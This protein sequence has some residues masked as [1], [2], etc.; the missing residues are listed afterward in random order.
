MN[1]DSSNRH[2]SVAGK[3]TPGPQ[4]N[5]GQGN[6]IRAR[7]MLYEGH[8]FLQKL[9]VR[10][11]SPLCLLIFLSIFLAEPVWQNAAVGI[12]FA[13]ASV[14][15]LYATR[16]T[17]QGRLHASVR[18]LMFGVILFEMVSMV[19]MPRG[20]ALGLLA[21]AIVIIYASF[22]TLRLLYL[23]IGATFASYVAVELLLYLDVVPQKPMSPLGLAIYGVGFSIIVLGVIFTALRHGKKMHDAL[24]EQIQ[25]AYQEQRSMLSTASRLEKVLE[26]TVYSIRDVSVRFSEQALDQSSSIAQMSG[27]LGQV[28]EIAATT[29]ASAHRT[30]ALAAK[31]QERASHSMEKLKQV[32]QGFG[33]VVEINELVKA[34]FDD[35]AAQ[36]ERIEDILRTN[37][38]L[39]AQIKI[40]AVNA[41]IQAAKAGEYGMGFRVV[42]GEL[43]AMIQRTDDSLG[44]SR[45]LLDGIRTRALKSAETISRSSALLGS[46]S[47]EL[48][49]T[50][51]MI[52]EITAGVVDTS[53]QVLGISESAME[54]QRR[55]DEVG[56]GM[57]QID[58]AAD[59][60]I[61]STQ[62]LRTSIDLIVDS[63][64]SLKDILAQT[65]AR[66]SLD[67][68]AGWAEQD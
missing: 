63:Q 53:H 9:V 66:T 39:A 47:V 43:K 59:N 20:I 55:L 68:N 23:A 50:G 46:H 67:P 52:E 38:E 36:A 19:L 16:L 45:K 26:S 29:A 35:L 48:G 58:D 18:V 54:Q 10:A 44:A 49:D 60:L 37:R 3:T 22:F 6:I 30:R 40:L 27:V 31:L 32:E 24:L 34:E 62:E 61:Q 65:D 13:A 25:S 14:A 33:R 5:G 11:V 51:K 12:A 41:G 21:D 15:W 1:N 17:A 28:R 64:S 2:S 8:L 57:A 7:Q 42:A 4:A 56:A